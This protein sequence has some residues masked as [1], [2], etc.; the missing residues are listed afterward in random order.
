MLV[1]DVPCKV[2]KHI[3]DICTANTSYATAV[4]P[5][6]KDIS[7]KF[8]HIRKVMFLFKYCGVT[9]NLGKNFKNLGRAKV[10]TSEEKPFQLFYKKRNND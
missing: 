3:V 9:G 6:D 4:V 10:V 1:R 2:F 7:I 5:T 8:M